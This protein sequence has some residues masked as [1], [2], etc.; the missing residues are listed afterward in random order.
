M[1]DDLAARQSLLTTLEAIPAV[2]SEARRHIDS[3]RAWITS[4]APL[5]RTEKPATPP[6]HLVAYT[7]LRDSDTERLLLVHHRKAGLLLP[8]GGH[9]EP[10]EAPW[11]T[12]VRE[13]GEEFDHVVSGPSQEPVFVSVT[14][15]R[16]AGRHVDVSLWFVIDADPNQITW[17]DQ[18]EFD[19]IAWLT[20]DEILAMPADTLDPHMHRFLTT[21]QPIYPVGRE[22]D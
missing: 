15:T 22:S 4:G 3:A 19:G 5:W 6:T 9:V 10:G 2:D 7:L 20:R 16:G 17:Y 14:E 8:A 12:A 11:A 1:Y 18:T 21:V 13:I